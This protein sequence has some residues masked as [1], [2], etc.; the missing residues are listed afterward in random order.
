MIRKTLLVA[1]F[2]LSLIPATIAFAAATPGCYTRDT[3]TGQFA[4]T[5]C[6]NDLST[7]PDSC[8]LADLLHPGISSFTEKPCDTI[9]VAVDDSFSF[10][11]IDRNDCSDDVLNKD[12]CGIVKIIIDIINALSAIV[13][14]V[15]VAV[16]VVS[17][18]K[19]SA[20]ADDPKAVSDAKNHI[21]NALLAFVFFIFLYAFLQWVVPGGII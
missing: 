16:I 8:Y 2:A 13:G 21:K 15:I 3:E 7:N 20:S 17:G 12:N 18:I 5:S 1:I 19:Y 10:G 9:T 6:P 14:V 11:D 4:A